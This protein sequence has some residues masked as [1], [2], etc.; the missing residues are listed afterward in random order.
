MQSPAR[1]SGESQRHRG[2]SRP[3]RMILL[4]SLF[5][6][7][8]AAAPPPLAAASDRDPPVARRIERPRFVFDAGAVWRNGEPWVDVQ[9][10]VPYSELMFQHEGGRYLAGFDLI[11]VLTSDGRQLTG[12]LWHETVEAHTVAESRS[13]TTLY[14]RFL[15]LRAK[16]GKLRVEVTVSEQS[17]GNEGRLVQEMEIPEPNRQPLQVGKIW[18]ARCGADSSSSLHPAA[19]DLVIGRRFGVSSG[20][21]CASM[22]VFVSGPRDTAGIGIHWKIVGDRREAVAE[23]RLHFDAAGDT[24]PVSFPLPV[25]SLWL[26]GYEL[27]IEASARGK[28]ITRITEFDMDETTV[29]LIHNPAESIALVRYIATSEELGKL[30]DAAPEEREKAWADFWKSRDPTPDTEQNEFKEEF[31]RRVRFAN[32]NFSSLGPGWRTDRGMIYIQYGP[33]DL[34]ESYPHNVDGPPYEVWSYYNLRKRFTFMDYD[35]F[36]RYELYTPGRLR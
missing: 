19:G 26:G 17:S 27:W 10:A 22:Q 35:G 14:T 32:E 6:S 24:I 31:F 7:L 29:S 11:A 13:S 30:E 20:P 23:K 4:A 34:I 25:Q 5:L 36:G 9:I 21:I 3:R 28:T 16:P 15:T 33:P 1:F 8:A 18:F 2:V 12:D